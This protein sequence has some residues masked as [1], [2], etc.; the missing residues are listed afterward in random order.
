[1]KQFLIRGRGSKSKHA[2]ARS[3]LFLGYTV[4]LILLLSAS[5]PSCNSTKEPV[6]IGFVGALTGRYSDLGVSGRDGVIL[7]VEEINQKGGLLGRPVSLL[8]RDDRQDPQAAVE[9]DKELITSGVIAIIGH[10]TSTMSMAAIPLMNSTQTVMISPTTASPLLSGQ[11]D[12]FFRSYEPI[13]KEVLEL[14]QWILVK[15]GTTRMAVLY[16]LGNK[17]FAGDYAERF[18]KA[19][20]ALGGQVLTTLGTEASST[21]DVLLGAQRLIDFD[22]EAVLIVH[23]ALDTLLVMETLRKSGWK[24]T[25]FASPWSMTKEM[26]EQGG[27]I[28]EGLCS[29][30][31]FLPD[32]PSPAYQNFRKSFLQRFKREPD[33]PAL[34]GYEA[35]QVLFRA[36]EKARA[37]GQALAEAILEIREFEGL[38]SKIVMDEFGDPKREKHPVVIRKGRM[39]RAF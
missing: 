12:F 10:M 6:R 28:A 32:H 30:V 16:D 35:A 15:R 31:P 39:E 5:T 21:K 25:A 37:P 4:F 3:L 8:T 33:F 17:T 13:D 34:F 20:R 23:N 27:V 9:A 11:K 1:M 18:E 36:Y 38:Q 26:L 22:I 24:G 29:I 7:A 19:Y 2:G 14:A